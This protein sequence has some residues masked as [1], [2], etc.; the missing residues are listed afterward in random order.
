M[1]VYA[2]RDAPNSPPAEPSPPVEPS[3]RLSGRPRANE[4]IHAILPALVLRTSEEK[5][6]V[7]GA[8]RELEVPRI[9]Y[10]KSGKFR[11]ML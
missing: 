4:Q 6:A 9:K 8:D 5:V 7:A 3:P 2:S 11:L 1:V 10:N